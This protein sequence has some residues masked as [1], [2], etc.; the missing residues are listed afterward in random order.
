V[1]DPILHCLLTDDA[2]ILPTD[3]RGRILYTDGSW[4]RAVAA[5]ARAGLLAWDAQGRLRYHG[6]AG[7]PRQAAWRV[8]AA[9]MGAHAALVHLRAWIATR[10]HPALEAAQWPREVMDLLL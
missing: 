2:A 10:P 9:E 6:L 8:L 5:C 4:S 7:S 1:I 3:G